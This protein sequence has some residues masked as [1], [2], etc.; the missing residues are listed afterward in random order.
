[1]AHKLRKAA[2]TL[3][4]LLALRD[5][6][7]NAEAV[8]SHAPQEHGSVHSSE[9]AFAELQSSGDGPLRHAQF[10]FDDLASPTQLPSVAVS[11]GELAEEAASED[12]KSSVEA[13]SLGAHPSQSLRRTARIV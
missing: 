1:M 6:E 7:G 10:G 11:N 13:A 9:P 2:W 3:C 12:D 8:N 4:D 5:V